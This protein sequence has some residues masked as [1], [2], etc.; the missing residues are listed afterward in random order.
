MITRLNDSERRLW[1][2]NTEHL[3]SRWRESGKGITAFVRENRKE[4]D[5]AILPV[6][7]AEPRGAE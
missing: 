7:N 5:G 2:E 6:L 3:Y 4:I 1:V